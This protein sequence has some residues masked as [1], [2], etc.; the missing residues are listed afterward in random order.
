MIEDVT[1]YHAGNGTPPDHGNRI[2]QMLMTIAERLDELARHQ[3]MMAERIQSL[4]DALHR[5]GD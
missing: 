1:P 2:D 5:L 3:V 4:T